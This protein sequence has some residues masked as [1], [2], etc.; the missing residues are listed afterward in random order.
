MNVFLDY[1]LSKTFT[2]DMRKANNL[3]YLQQAILFNQLLKGGTAVDTGSKR[4]VV[5]LTGTPLQNV[6]V[7]DL[8]L[9]MEKIS[10]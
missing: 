8:M 4:N 6:A 9:E 7:V 1:E 10:L 5:R 2:G 3:G